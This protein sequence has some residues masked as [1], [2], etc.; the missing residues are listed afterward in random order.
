[1]MPLNLGS[2]GFRGI[3][4]RVRFESS[5]RSASVTWTGQSDSSPSPK[6]KMYSCFLMLMPPLTPDQAVSGGFMEFRAV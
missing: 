2:F 3:G 6:P 4:W 1:M 5:M